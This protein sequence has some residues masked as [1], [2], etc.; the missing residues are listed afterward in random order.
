MNEELTPDES[1]R[2]HEFPQADENYCSCCR[3]RIIDGLE[4]VVRIQTTPERQLSMKGEVLGEE[5]RKPKYKAYLHARCWKRHFGQVV[6]CEKCGGFSKY[7][8]LQDGSQNKCACTC[9]HGSNHCSYV[10]DPNRI[11]QIKQTQRNL[12]L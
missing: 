2:P 3:G 11:D 6:D 4:N 10:L 5:N 8:K 1:H 7:T 9:H 12:L